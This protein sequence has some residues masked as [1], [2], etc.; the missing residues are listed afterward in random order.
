MRELELGS[1]RS[2][3]RCH[4]NHHR[5]NRHRWNRHLEDPLGMEIRASD[6]KYHA[7]ARFCL[8]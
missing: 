4:W 2:R 1:R 6:E 8:S 5:R 3:H 7:L